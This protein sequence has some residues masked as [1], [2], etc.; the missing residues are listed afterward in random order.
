MGK[1]AFQVESG[2]RV[3]SETRDR[4]CSA[5]KPETKADYGRPQITEKL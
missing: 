2:G 3:S 1:K 4:L 5:D